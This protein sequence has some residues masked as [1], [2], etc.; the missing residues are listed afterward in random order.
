MPGRVVAL[1]AEEGS[2]VEQGQG[3]LVLEAMKMENEIAAERDGTLKKLFVELG[4]PVEG[5]DPLFE[6]E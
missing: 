4:Q 2:S 6:I 1:L 5:G 3:I